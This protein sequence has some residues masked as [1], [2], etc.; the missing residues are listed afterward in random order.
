MTRTLRRLIVLCALTI[1]IAIGGAHDARAGEAGLVIEHGDG[2]VIYVLIVFPEDELKS[3]DLLKRSGISLATVS[4]G[5]LGEAVCTIDNEGCGVSDCRVRLCQTGDP[6][7][8]FW[9]FFRAGEDGVWIVQPLG[10]SGTTVRGGEVDLWAW[11]GGDASIPT[12]DLAGVAAPVGAP[13]STWKKPSTWPGTAPTATRCPLREP[14]PV[15]KIR[16]S[17]A[18]RYLPSRR[19]PAFCLP[20]EIVPAHYPAG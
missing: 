15:S 16:G 11:T 6:E 1:A 10:A 19:F 14:I 13:D 2:S 5:G 20:G 8:P 18:L 4:A 17:A 7:S 9:K 12:V 3:I